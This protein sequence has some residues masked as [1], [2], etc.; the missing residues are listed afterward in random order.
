[1]ERFER[2]ASRR[3]LIL[4]YEVVSDTS[5]SVLPLWL[6]RLTKQV[7]VDLGLSHRVMAS[8]AGHDAQILARGCPPAMLFV[9]SHAGLSHVPEEW[10]SVED[11][12]RG[13][14]ALSPACSGWTA[15]SQMRSPDR[16]ETRYNC[17]RWRPLSV[18]PGSQRSRLPLRRPGRRR[19]SLRPSSGARQTASTEWSKWRPWGLVPMLRLIVQTLLLLVLALPLTGVA[20]AADADPARCPARLLASARR[21]E[22]TLTETAAKT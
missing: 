7:C 17:A 4:E 13:V 11:V 14:R 9:P 22:A 2:I 5:P 10:T 19:R 12:T 8:G 16:G 20:H 15:S 21:P 1:M 18:S 3:G 6:R